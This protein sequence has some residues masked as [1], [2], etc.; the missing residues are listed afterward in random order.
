MTAFDDRRDDAERY[1]GPDPLFE[2]M[3]HRAQPDKVLHLLEA[4]FD[5]LTAKLIA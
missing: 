3:V 1:V 5:I 4:P 2:P